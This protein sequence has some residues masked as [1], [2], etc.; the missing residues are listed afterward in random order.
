[1]VGEAGARGG[2]FSTVL[3][4]KRGSMAKK[5]K[6]KLQKKSQHI[7]FKYDVW[8]DFA[9]K[10]FREGIWGTWKKGRRVRKLP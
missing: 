1:M 9:G 8:L 3:E 6:K 5:K 7:S 10:I 2:V 4:K